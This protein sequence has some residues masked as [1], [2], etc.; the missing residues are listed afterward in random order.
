MA[1]E[2]ILSQIEPIPIICIKAAAASTGAVATLLQ[3]SAE[4]INYHEY[5]CTLW[6]GEEGDGNGQWDT[7]VGSIPPQ[8]PIL[9]S[10][11]LPDMSHLRTRITIRRT[12]WTKKKFQKV[13][14][15]AATV[16]TVR[17]HIPTYY[18]TD[19]HH[20]HYYKPDNRT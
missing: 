5:E 1:K 14:N 10:S 12:Y 6:S 8:N 17:T 7:A 11:R 9:L 15:T 2:N 20:G 18:R 4:I 3:G 13:E 19:R 16:S